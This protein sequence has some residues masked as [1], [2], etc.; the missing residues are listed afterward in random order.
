MRLPGFLSLEFLSTFLHWA[1]IKTCFSI[2]HFPRQGLSFP[3][4]HFLATL[5]VPITDFQCKITMIHLFI[6]F[7]RL[8]NPLA[9]ATLLTLQF[10]EE[11]GCTLKM[12]GWGMGVS[13]LVKGPQ[14]QPCS[15]FLCCSSWCSETFRL[16]FTCQNSALILF[17]FPR[18][19]VHRITA[20]KV[21]NDPTS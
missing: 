18:M 14:E 3:L 4:W 17:V 20:P 13:A 11:P 6:C 16:G 15:S 7:P 8:R 1:C 5:C 19:P 9:R 10:T 21:P 2:P 12:Q